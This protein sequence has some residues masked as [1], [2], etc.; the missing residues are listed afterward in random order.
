MSKVFKRA[1]PPKVSTTL[2]VR[3][4]DTYY[5]RL[6]YYNIAACIVPK[7]LVNSMTGQTYRVLATI[8]NAYT[9]G[10]LNFHRKK[11]IKV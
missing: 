4:A 7:R 2:F 11:G 1:K 9:S 3:L 10:I 5:D 6:F 8:D